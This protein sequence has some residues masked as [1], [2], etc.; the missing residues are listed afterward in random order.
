MIKELLTRKTL[1]YPFVLELPYVRSDYTEFGGM[2]IKSREVLE[3]LSSE[4]N[5]CEEDFETFFRETQPL[6]WRVELHEDSSYALPTLEDLQ[7]YELGDTKKTIEEC[8]N[9][10]DSFYRE[11]E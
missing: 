3:T 8:S 11:F 1:T 4:F 10:Y 9:V 6:D 7:V 5:N 2:L